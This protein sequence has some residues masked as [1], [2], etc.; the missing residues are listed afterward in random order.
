MLKNK[1]FQRQYQKQAK[2]F[3]FISWSHISTRIYQK[4]FKG[5]RKEYIIMNVLSI[6]INEKHFPKTT[7]Q[8]EFGLFTNL[9]RIIIAC[10]FF[11]SS[12]KLRRGIL[13]W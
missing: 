11:S 13:P 9:S 1:I 4:K 2:M 8:W 12:F 5:S 10:D 7:S 3:V 6:S